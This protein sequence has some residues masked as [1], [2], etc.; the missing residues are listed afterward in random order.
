[1]AINNGRFIGRINGKSLWDYYYALDYDLKTLNERLNHL[2]KVFNLVDIGGV[3]L[4]DD[5]FWQDIWDMGVCKSGINTTDPLWSETN[6]SKF[7]SKC[8][9]YL[10]EVY[11]PDTSGNERIKVYTDRELFE[12]IVNDREIL[13]K[14]ADVNGDELAVFVPSNKNYKEV[15]DIEVEDSDIERYSEIKAYNDLRER[16]LYLHKNPAERKKMAREKGLKKK[17]LSDMLNRNRKLL[18]DDMLDV[19]ISKERPII[20]KSPLKDSGNEI[21]W[22]YLDMFDPEHVKPLLQVYKDMDIS[23]D[24]LITRDSLLEKVKLTD[25]QNEILRLWR[26]DVT[27]QDIADYLGISRQVVIKQLDKIVKQVINAYEKE[28]EENY[29]Y[30]NVVKGKYKKC[31]KC[32]EIKLIQRFDK[33]GKKGYRSNCKAC[34]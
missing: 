21:D 7:L 29:Y 10:L 28:Y 18:E 8:A 19:K 9:D 15:K 13:T 32:G 6:V 17:E 16:L 25:R 11:K 1:M 5:E 2:K 31:S 34:N 4:S 22:D 3:F 27:Q 23:S 24:M 14:S 30:L 26:K 20:W 12:R 33:N